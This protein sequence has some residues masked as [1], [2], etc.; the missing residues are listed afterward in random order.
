MVDQKTLNL[1]GTMKKVYK[2]QVKIMT[3]ET[4][5]KVFHTRV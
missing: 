2:W 5:L 1:I 3:G 4:R